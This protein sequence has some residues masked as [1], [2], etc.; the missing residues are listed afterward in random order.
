MKRMILLSI[1]LL[2]ILTTFSLQTQALSDTTGDIQGNVTDANGDPLG[3]ATVKLLNQ[4]EVESETTTDFDGNFVFVNIMPGEYT[5]NISSAGYYDEEVTVIANEITN[6]SIQVKWKQAPPPD[7]DDDDQQPSGV[8]AL[9]SNP[10]ATNVPTPATGSVNSYVPADP[11]DPTIISMVTN[12]FDNR[13]NSG[14]P[15]TLHSTQNR[16]KRNPLTLAQISGIAESQGYTVN[17][18]G[19][20]LSHATV[21]PAARRCVSGNVGNG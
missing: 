4:T 11:N 8:A 1:C 7:D 12:Y 15:A 6:V 2:C 20:S 10:T 13:Y 5:L 14:T 18:N 21:K 3:Y 9:F 19:G 17:N 16:M